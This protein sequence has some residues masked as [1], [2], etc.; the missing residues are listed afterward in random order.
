MGDIAL[1]LDFVVSTE[2]HALAFTGRGLLHR[3]VGYS[4]GCGTG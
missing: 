2:R 4:C 1:A 3:A